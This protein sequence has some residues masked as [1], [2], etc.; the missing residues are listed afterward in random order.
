MIRGFVSGIKKRQKKSLVLQEED[1]MDNFEDYLI[2]LKSSSQMFEF[3]VA[4]VSYS[5]R[6]YLIHRQKKNKL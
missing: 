5:Y 2:T 1:C 4:A 3:R 6:E